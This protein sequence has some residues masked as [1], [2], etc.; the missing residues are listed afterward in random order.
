MEN[1]RRLLAATFAALATAVLA[2]AAQ[3]ACRDCGTVI[4][5][6]KVEKAGE[7]SGAGAVLGGIAGGVLGHQIGSGRGNTAATVA[8]AAGGAY[9][10]HQIEK[11]RNKT[12]SYEVVVEMEDGARRTFTYRDPT[13]FHTGD[14]VRIVDHKL[15]HR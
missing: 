4:D 14:K 15:R 7:A 6:K 11:N 1:A 13:G 5:V 10:G 9:A 3:A 12:V 8:G 2:P